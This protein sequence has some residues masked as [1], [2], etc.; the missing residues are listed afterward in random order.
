MKSHLE[1]AT[2]GDLRKLGAGLGHDGLGHALNIVLASA[3]SL[4]E[5][6][7]LLAL[8]AGAVLLEWV[9]AGSVTGSAGNDT[10]THTLTTGV[11]DGLDD[12]TVTSDQGSGQDSSGDEALERHFERE[13]RVGV[14][15]WE[16]RGRKK[17][18]VITCPA[19]M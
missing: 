10:E 17:R 19:G 8:E 11:A 4:A 12:G 7:G 3:N 13:V 16:K 1:A 6:V 9:P 18:I 14:C 5:G 2:G 15:V